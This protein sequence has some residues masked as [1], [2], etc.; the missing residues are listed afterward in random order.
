MKII[1]SHRYL[2]FD[3]LA[4]MVAVQ[5][6]YPDAVLVIEG[7]NNSY[8]QDFLALAKEHLPFY[9]LKDIDP[10]KV[11][12]IFLV[13][14]NNLSRAV[15]NKN[16]L[17]RFS[18]VDLEII[19][20]H[21]SSGPIGKNHTFQALGACTTIL[22]EKIKSKGIKL[23][24][25]DATLMT[26]GIYD[27]T[28]SLLF[29]NTT[30][31]D[32][33]AVAHLIDQGAQLGVVAEYLRKPLSGEQMDLFQ[34]LLDNGSTEL[35]EGTPVYFTYAECRDFVEG[36][37]LLT[38][39]IG[40]IESAD[41]WFIIVKMEDRVYVVARSRGN[42]FPVNKIVEIFGGSGHEKA[43]SAVVK[44]RDI[45]DVIRQIREEIR[46]R[47][48]K[49]SLIRDIMS[50]PVKT[51]FPDMTMEEVGKILLK[52]GHTGVPVVDNDDRL[53]GIISRR[54]VDKA[55][56][57]GLQHAPAK[58]FMTKDVVTVSPDLSWEEV[59][60]KMVLH[61]IGRLPV[62]ENG[63]LVGI[64]SRSDILR[65]IYGRAVPTTTMLARERSMA[66]REEI[67]ALINKLPEEIK[68]A[69]ETIKDV[70][71]EMDVPIYLVGGFVRDLLL[72][73]ANKDLDM[74]VEG[75]G[76]A[77]AENLSQ[78][79]YPAKVITHQPFG[80]A[81]IMMDDGTHF[82]IAG[83]RREDYDYPGALPTVEEST[84]KDDLFR[85]DFTINAMAMCLNRERF[86]EVVD[87]YGGFRDLQ[88]GEIRFL[89]NL[90][91]IDDPTR[92]VRAIRFSE[93]Y[94]FKLAKNTR[95]A[96]NIALEAKVFAKIS[97]ERFTEELMLIY[98][99]ANYQ[100]M[101]RK[102]MEYGVFKSWFDQDFP[103]NFQEE[104]NTSEWPLERRWLVSLKSI[105]EQG[106][107]TILNGL[108]INKYLHKSTL[109]YLRLRQ[110]LKSRISDLTKMD[111]VL[112]PAPKNLVDVL[113]RH[114]EFAAEIRHY[115]EVS[116]KVNMKITGT[117]LVE[118]GMKEGPEIGKTLRR[119]RNLWLEGKIRSIEEEKEYIQNTLQR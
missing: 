113:L 32:V 86:G 19:D 8:V 53:V 71:A 1:L 85:R 90:S 69:L 18:Q 72:G 13:D 17:D 87:F 10:G 112:M 12:K 6:I 49:P 37:A 59:Q 36:L 84:L 105:E 114:G 99:E 66:R 38:H 61:D 34:L 74:V 115:I 80:T 42:N 56:K 95:D 70:S 40:E 98:K 11:E 25:F 5:K 47:I 76:I 108:R 21:P 101:G 102:L 107:H 7:K 109:E 82:D 27:D 60:K 28:G 89:H 22:V 67:L 104:E 33:M 91:F 100:K 3:A 26:L 51:V 52:Y 111:E 88:Q 16:I 68:T 77:F 55:L 23:S 57:H 73:V 116:S 94:G 24:S 9:R 2:D 93:R 81:R 79:L 92:I 117:Q 103:W 46:K 78:R 20:H 15:G 41:I 44:E 39:R 75:D 29:E 50:F 110:E 58:G 54:D 4:S 65:L 31:R 30:S 35:F 14:T 119:I 83:S 45:Q 43:A 97:A 62:V 96:V 118:S 63:Q 64:V 48:E 106:V